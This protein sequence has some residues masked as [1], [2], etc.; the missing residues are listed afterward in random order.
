MA[1]DREAT[2]DRN[3]TIGRSKNGNGATGAKNYASVHF[4][5]LIAAR[6]LEIRLS[7]EE[8]AERMG[9]SQSRVARIEAG[10]PI[11]AE[12]RERLTDALGMEPEPNPLRRMMAR[13]GGNGARIPVE[14]IGR[15]I[16]GGLSATR[17]ALERPAAALDLERAKSA[18]GRVP[19][20]AQ[21]FDGLGRARDALSRM[22]KPALAI[23]EARVPMRA[24]LGLV[25]AAVIAFLLSLIVVDAAWARIGLTAVTVAAVGLS[26][27]LLQRRADARVP[28]AIAAAIWLSVIAVSLISSGGNAEGSNSSAAIEKTSAAP[29]A[30]ETATLAQNA[31]A[32]AAILGSDAAAASRKSSVPTK[33]H[34]AS[35]SDTTVIPTEQPISPSTGSSV[36]S[37]TPSSSG[38]KPGAKPGGLSDNQ[39]GS[40][41]SGSSSGSTGAQSGSGSGSSGPV[42]NI[43]NSLGNAH[44]RP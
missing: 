6:R 30:P 42:G 32:A 35:T 26:M 34:D 24:A 36:P 28:V 8:L 17:Q 38:G 18:L 1:L 2:L 7:Q 20:R 14:P 10:E 11:S 13:G 44:Q 23:G 12:T 41:G 43:V 5:R 15:R 19:E 4:G 33:S 27:L 22:P 16:T 39:G 3:A 9:T 29:A 25:A 40:S 31:S 21:T 37:S